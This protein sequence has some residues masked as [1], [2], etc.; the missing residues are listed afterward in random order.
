MA[1]KRLTAKQAQRLRED[2]VAA[3][4]QEAA[5]RYARFCKEVEPIV[6]EIVDSAAVVIEHAAKHA[7]SSVTMTR[8]LDQNLDAEHYRAIMEGCSTAFKLLHHHQQ[9]R[10]TQRL[11]ITGAHIMAKDIRKRAR[12]A[13]AK[14]E[15]ARA[16]AVAYREL[17][18]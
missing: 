3:A 18:R 6:E 10:P 8:E 4:R 5:D 13:A 16:A 7:H 1:K 2:A 17:P 12:A 14:K 9:G 15:A 11:R